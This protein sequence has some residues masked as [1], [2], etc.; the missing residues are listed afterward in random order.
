VVTRIRIGIIEDVETHHLIATENWHE[1]VAELAGS[2]LG[3]SNGLSA[4]AEDISGTDS[5]PDQNKKHSRG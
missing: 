2:D 1:C 3:T 4:T 5:L